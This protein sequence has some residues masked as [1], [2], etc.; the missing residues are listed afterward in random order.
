[1]NRACLALGSLLLSATALATEPSVRV[2]PPQLQG[3]RPLEPQTANSVVKDYLESWKS[4]EQALDQNDATRL[5]ADFVGVAHD[6]L[7]E[8]V[9][10]QLR[11]GLHTHYEDRSHDLQIVFYSLDGLSIQM[12]D[13][14]EYVQ[15]VMGK[16]KELASTT[17]RQR[18][19]VVLTPSETRWQ[20]RIFQ[21]AAS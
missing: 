15:K 10:G 9:A 14:V 1:M 16:D 2:E 3:S 20:V 8:T 13:T 17:V 5:D 19:V 4:F 18:Y 21:A 7:A 6:R 12:I 11:G